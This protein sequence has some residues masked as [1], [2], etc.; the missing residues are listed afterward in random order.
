MN[1]IESE[2]TYEKVCYY[3]LPLKERTR[4]VKLYRRFSGIAIEDIYRQLNTPMNVTNRTMP[5]ETRWAYAYR[6]KYGTWDYKPNSYISDND[7]LRALTAA[8][9]AEY[10]KMF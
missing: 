5:L 4:I 3:D 1:G 2:K 9:A 6:K 8:E 10:N 7:I